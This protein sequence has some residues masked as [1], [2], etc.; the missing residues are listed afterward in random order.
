MPFPLWPLRAGSV[1]DPPFGHLPDTFSWHSKAKLGNM[2][3]A[4][5]RL[6]AIPRVES[7]IRA[8]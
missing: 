4:V 6:S 3:A 1:A 2:K 8:V 5:M 7:G